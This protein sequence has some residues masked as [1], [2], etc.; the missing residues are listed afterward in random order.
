M[1][2]EPLCV[3]L[4]NP[5]F[6]SPRRTRLRNFASA[7]AWIPSER[8]KGKSANPSLLCWMKEVSPGWKVVQEPTE[9]P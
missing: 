3:T 7:R 4:M 1:S 9:D 2:F 6:V 5:T 8:S